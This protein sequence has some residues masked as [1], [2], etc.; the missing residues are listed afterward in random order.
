[1]RRS[2]EGCHEG[3]WGSLFDRTAHAIFLMLYLYVMRKQIADDVV[4]VGRQLLFASFL[5]GCLAVASSFVWRCDSGVQLR[6]DNLII[7]IILQ[8]LSL[9]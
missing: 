7:S 1:M 9:L 2:N 3:I 5:V 6:C 8:S 4:A